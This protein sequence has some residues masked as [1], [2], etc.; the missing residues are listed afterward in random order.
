M[1]NRIEQKVYYKLSFNVDLQSVDDITWVREQMQVLEKEPDIMRCFQNMTVDYGSLGN[2]P[3]IRNKNWSI[4][5][6]AK[7]FSIYYRKEDNS[8]ID[9]FLFKVKLKFPNFRH[10]ITQTVKEYF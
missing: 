1:T 9:R 7:G 6:D 3:N 2:N 10:E 5:D 8:T 4:E